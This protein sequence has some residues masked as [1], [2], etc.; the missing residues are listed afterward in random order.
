VYEFT[1][2]LCARTGVALA[3]IQGTENART[4]CTILADH[5][6]PSFHV[7]DPWLHQ[8]VPD[9]VKCNR[10]EVTEEGIIVLLHNSLQKAVSWGELSVL[11]CVRLA[12]TEQQRVTKTGVA[13]VGSVLTSP[14]WIGVG[15]GASGAAA[16]AAYRSGQPE[17]VSKDIVKHFL[18]V[19]SESANVSCAMDLDDGAIVRPYSFLATVAKPKEEWLAETL[20]QRANGA[21]AGPGIHRLAAQGRSGKWYDLSMNSPDDI[22]QRLAWLAALRKLE[23]V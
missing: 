18:L 14:G 4:V 8:L 12:S 5:G 13:R 6:I 15:I 20:L 10:I 7:S 19:Y 2:R 21:L 17:T 22:R 3:R 11:E 1:R 16:L 9:L 23:L